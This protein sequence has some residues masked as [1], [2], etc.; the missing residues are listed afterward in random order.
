MPY[1]KLPNAF[2]KLPDI[3]NLDKAP[4]EPYKMPTL[5]M[6]HSSKF[7]EICKVVFNKQTTIPKELMDLL[8]GHRLESIIDKLELDELADIIRHVLIINKDKIGW[9]V[10][11]E[12]NY[13][14]NKMYTPRWELPDL[15]FDQGLREVFITR[16][17][18]K[19]N[20]QLQDA[21]LVFFQEYQKFTGQQVFFEKE[22][23]PAVQKVWSF[24]QLYLILN[25]VS[26]LVKKYREKV[27][28]DQYTPLIQQLIRLF[29][30]NY[31]NRIYS[32]AQRISLIFLVCKASIRSGQIEIS[33]LQI[34][35]DNSMTL[36]KQLDSD[37]QKSYRLLY[38]FVYSIFWYN[39]FDNTSDLIMQRDLIAEIIEDIYKPEKMELDDWA[40]YLVSS[41]PHPLVI[42]LILSGYTRLTKMIKE[43]AKSL[44]PS[45]QR[46]DLL[47]IR[48]ELV[49]FIHDLMFNYIEDYFK[50][51]LEGYEFIKYLNDARENIHFSNFVRLI[52]E[53]IYSTWKFKIIHTPVLRDNDKLINKFEEY[54]NHIFDGG[55][56]LLE[57]VDFMI[58]AGRYQFDFHAQAIINDFEESNSIILSETFEQTVIKVVGEIF[59][60][61]QKE[62]ETNGNI[63]INQYEVMILF[64]LNWMTKLYNTYS[65]RFE[66]IMILSPL[67]SIAYIQ[68][69]KGYLD[70][71]NLEGAFLAYFNSY[72]LMEIINQDLKG[73]TLDDPVDGKSINEKFQQLLKEWGIE[74]ISEKSYMKQLFRSIEVSIA[75][76]TKNRE[77]KSFSM[78]GMLDDDIVMGYLDMIT[79]LEI[80]NQMIDTTTNV[81]DAVTASELY[82]PPIVPP[83]FRCDFFGD[84]LDNQLR[85]QLPLPIIRNIATASIGIKLYPIELKLPD[86]ALDLDNAVPDIN[87]LGDDEQDNP[88][89]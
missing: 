40:A 72:Y 35:L 64:V 65:I 3:G 54:L 85:Q 62:T 18:W 47:I 13:Y 57:N 77:D 41:K 84:T 6:I 37:A 19:P 7:K 12:I 74:E 15:A 68:L 28:V 70:R 51:K 63:D 1:N 22:I 9:E 45:D 20:Q 8:R 49:D 60:A 75:T 81:R 48:R 23:N 39:L 88:D 78:G 80:F 83:V 61:I 66:A 31:K 36:I 17:N 16:I 30:E 71:N 25:E 52:E 4:E 59:S 76:R 32:E 69:A 44:P 79:Q 43:Y 87:T 46:D 42:S 5:G 50:I 10:V 86:T 24:R 55:I 67:I 82:T 29:E 11:D 21:L 27:K 14:L 89:S 2:L 33:R 73:S 53:I 34:L 58:Q 38:G 56:A 26:Y